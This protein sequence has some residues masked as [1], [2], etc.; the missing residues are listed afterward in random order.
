MLLIAV[1]GWVLSPSPG[2][3]SSSRGSFSP[4]ESGSGGEWGLSVDS[5]TSSLK[6]PPLPLFLSSLYV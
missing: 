5:V 2:P 3:V 6:E 4:D 1:L